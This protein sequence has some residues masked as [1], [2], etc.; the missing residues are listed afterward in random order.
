[1]KRFLLRALVFIAVAV[2]TAF[3]VNKLNNAGLDRVSKE[4]DEPTL[5]YVYLEFDGKVINRT[6]GYTQTMSTSLMREGIVPLNSNHGVTALVD[7]EG[8]YGETFTYELRSIAG[9]SLVER[10][11]AT[12]G[13]VVDG[14]KR[15][16]V[17]FRMDMQPNREYVFV[18]IITAKDGTEV[19]YY[20]RV[21]NLS[22]QHAREIIDFASDFHNTTFVKKVNEAEGNIV[23]DNLRTD[24]AGTTSS[25]AHV[26]LNAT[27]EQITWGGLNPVVVTGVTPTIT[28]IDK[29]YAVI[30]MSYV[31]ESMNDK[32]SHYYQ[33]DEYYNA[34]Y[35]RSAETVDLL[36][37]DRYQ[38][39]FFDSGYISKDRNSISMGVTNETAE[40]VTSA[41]YNILAFVRLGQLWMYNYSTNALTNIFSYP[42]D[43]FSDARTLNTNLDINIAD[44]DE[45]GNIYF[46]VYGYM[47]RGEHE[48]KNGM[49]LYYYSTES[50]TTKELFFVECDESYDIMKKE[51]GRF[52]YYNAQADEFYYLLDETLYKVSL[53]DMTQTALVTDIP[54]AKYLVSAN[55]K[56]I[57]YPNAAEEDQVT[58]ITIQ[59]FETGETYEK[60]CAN[61]DLL[62]ALGFVENDLI[63][64][65]SHAADVITT[66]DGQAI[67]PLYELFIMS[68]RGEQKK[69][70]TKDGVYIMNA[71]V[72]EDTIY[73]TR[74]RKQNQFFEE[75][76]QD[77]I[78]YKKEEN[79]KMITTTTTYDSYAWDILDVVF[80]SNFYLSDSASYRKTKYSQSELYKE[81][82][83]T[84]KTR[85]GAY[86]VFDNAGYKGEYETAG[87]AIT[88]VVDDEAGLVV[89]SNG[90]TIYRC[91]AADSYNT[92]ADAIEE[93]A[94][95]DINQSL[96]TCAYMCAK[97]A[98]GT[99]ELADAINSG[100]F[101]KVF[102]DYTNGVGINI[103]GISLST[104]LYFLDRDIPFAARIDDGRYV[105]VISYNS[106]H[107]RYYDPVLGE[108]VKVTRKVFENSLSLQSNTMY[109]FSVQ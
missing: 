12:A 40:Y 100:T 74:A 95:A 26:D 88:R 28:E 96:L 17:N 67:L 33:V 97:Y 94:N 24:K 50:M 109:T 91:L 78:S 99:L 9:D 41:D 64:G 51:T 102:E 76:D 77:Y 65:S 71:S 107:I 30:H 81:M 98:G 73:L 82:Q 22:E 5:P 11:D 13:S 14:R 1:M 59:N 34:T 21:V 54:S 8:K 85:V 20:N 84:T 93:T 37:F 83:V 90:N 63:Y 36:A 61:G 44:M 69:D 38:E 86:Y 103:S 79:N 52:T 104:A 80:P 105:L 72:G 23:F 89:D 29:E 60:T 3:L 92:V 101:E 66:S 45:D 18:F 6:C 25:L 58:A 75:I 53:A 10:G 87:S 16:D 7:N 2:G 68:D 48:G 19:R 4:L 35:D 55:R 46:V 49:S 43:S 39:S 108:E 31:A 27:Y 57:A 56:L 70:Y 106:T 47:N 32:K 42:Q 15:Y 62:L